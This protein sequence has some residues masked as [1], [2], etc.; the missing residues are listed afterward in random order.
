MPD[1]ALWQHIE[2]SSGVAVVGLRKP[3]VNRGVYRGRV[4]MS[5]SEWEHSRH[6]IT[7]Q[8][9]VELIWA[10]TLLPTVKVRFASFDAFQ[11]VRRLPHSGYVE[12]L[13]AIGDMAPHAEGSFGCGNLGE[14]DEPRLYTN[15]TWGDVYSVKHR[16]MG[17]ENAWR[18]TAGAGVN[19]GVVDTGTHWAQ[20]QLLPAAMGGRFDAGESAGRSIRYRDAWNQGDVSPDDN[21]GHGTEVAGVIA[22]PK[23]GQG[24]IGVAWKSNLVVA[25]MSNGVVNVNSTDAQQAI[26]AAVSAMDYAPGGKII[27]MSWQ[28]M[29]W[30][31]QVSDEIDHWQNRHPHD[32]LFFGAAGTTADDWLECGLGV[33]GG[34]LAAAGVA[35]LWNPYAAAVLFLAG[36]IVGCAVP[37]NGNVVFPAEHPS[38]MAVTCLDLGTGDVSNN[39]HHG[40]KVEFAAY[41]RFPSVYGGYDRVDGLGGSSG[42]TPVVAGQAALIWSRYPHFTRAQVLDR[43]RWAGRGSKSSR[44]GYGIVNTYKAVGG[45]YE[46]RVD[47]QVTGG[48]FNQVAYHQLSVA[49]MGG[50]GPFTYL[51]NDGHTSASRSTEIGPGEPERTYSVV[52]TDTSDGGTATALY[53]VSPPPGGCEDPSQ[54]ECS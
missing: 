14:W 43:M 3:G 8:A 42:A 11:K 4:L 21:C 51:W 13:R 48:G 40:T 37:D 52:I 19:V 7:S 29:N 1:S 44:Q 41:Q 25:R 24:A 33:G 22:A 36:S 5:R 27:S 12:P 10:D 30:W 17:I 20:P 47:G 49:H 6:A 50:D 32:L 54:V 31:W 9:G 38:V 53:T 45:L 2:Y 15:G 35:V 18:R 23:D 34:G 16:A 39:C 28:S 46:A 26:R